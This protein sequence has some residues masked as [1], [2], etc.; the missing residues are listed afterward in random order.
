M[1]QFVPHANLAIVYKYKQVDRNPGHVDHKLL[2]TGAE[3]MQA[4]ATERSGVT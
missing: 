2:E 1:W 4:S 3:L